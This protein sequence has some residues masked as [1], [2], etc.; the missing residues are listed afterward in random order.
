MAESKKLEPPNNQHV[1]EG[2]GDLRTAEHRNSWNLDDSDTAA[3]QQRG[4]FDLFRAGGIGASSRQRTNQMTD[5]MADEIASGWDGAVSERGRSTAAYGR[6]DYGPDYDDPAY[7]PDYGP[8]DYDSSYNDELDQGWENFDN[9][10]DPPPPDNLAEEKST[11]YEKRIY[12]DEGLYDEGPY[13]GNAE[14]D[15][16]YEDEAYRD[17][18]YDG[19]VPLNEVGPDGVYEADYRVII[20]PSKPLDEDEEPLR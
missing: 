1:G 6:Q 10:D 4:L 15:E 19:E 11:A 17:D 13:A 20:P 14:Q 16:A 9:Y 12:G 8:E 2:W 3:G 5:Q 18:A 7:G